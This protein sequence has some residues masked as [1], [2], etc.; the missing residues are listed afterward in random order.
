MSFLLQFCVCGWSIGGT[1]DNKLDDDK[2]QTWSKSM[3]CINQLLGHAQDNMMQPFQLKTVWA[4]R[5]RHVWCNQDGGKHTHN[6][7]H[8]DKMCNI[9]Q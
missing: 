2:F 9:R 1:L 6:K 5:E 4:D 8:N 7:E 3:R